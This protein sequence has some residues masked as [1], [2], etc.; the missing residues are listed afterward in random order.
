MPRYFK[1]CLRS[2]LYTRQLLHWLSRAI[3][4]PLA[5][6][7]LHTPVLHICEVIEQN[8]SEVE[9]YDFC[10]LAFLLG[11]CSGFNLVKTPQRLGNWFQKYKQ[12]KN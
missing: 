6:V 8:E 9:K 1:S 11:Y 3:C 2:C 5:I 12:L 7:F 10:F 4:F